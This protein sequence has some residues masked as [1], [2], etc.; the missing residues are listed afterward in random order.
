MQSYTQVAKADSPPSK[1]ARYYLPDS[2]PTPMLKVKVKFMQ[3]TEGEYQTNKKA[4]PRRRT[5][6]RKKE[7]P[8]AHT[9]TVRQKEKKEKQLDTISRSQSQSQS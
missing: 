1:P 4:L 5:K 7:L 6:E 9:C 8:D 2:T 3:R